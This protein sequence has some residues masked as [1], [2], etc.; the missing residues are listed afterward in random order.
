M[1]ENISFPVFVIMLLDENNWLQCLNNTQK[2][3]LLQLASLFQFWKIMAK[4][5]RPGSPLAFNNF[6]RKNYQNG[7]DSVTVQKLLVL[8]GLTEKVA[9]I[10]ITEML[11]DLFF[12]LKKWSENKF[13]PV[14]RYQ[15]EIRPALSS[16]LIV[17][18]CVICEGFFFFNRAKVFF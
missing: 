6:P 12:F 10:K 3:K 7:S 14:N 4:I 11:N 17:T 8:D 2:K 18:T 16:V 15:W 9:T 1:R 5:S 13:W